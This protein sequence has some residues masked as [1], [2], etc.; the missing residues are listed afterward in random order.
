M[1]LLKVKKYKILLSVIV[2]TIFLLFIW[3]Y[4]MPYGSRNYFKLCDENKKISSDVDDL[5]RQNNE[6]KLE[7]SKLKE[8]S[9]YLETVAR[10]QFGLLKKNEI[11]FEFKEKK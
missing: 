8:D 3:I 10:E 4:F 1:H 9:Q 5:K 7:I 11:V 6:L 2:L